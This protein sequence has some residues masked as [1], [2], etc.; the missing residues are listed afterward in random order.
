MKVLCRLANSV[1]GKSRFRALPLPPGGGNLPVYE[2]L[3]ESGNPADL[4]FEL[5]RGL[6][7]PDAR[8]VKG[9]LVNFPAPVSQWGPVRLAKIASGGFVHV[10]SK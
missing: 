7:K 4:R 9:S 8:A 3:P 1:P 2:A 6:A 10:Y 5:P